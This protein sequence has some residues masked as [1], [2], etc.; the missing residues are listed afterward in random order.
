[1]S[2]SIFQNSLMARVLI[3][4]KVN[5][6]AVSTNMHLSVLNIASAYMPK[7]VNNRLQQFERLAALPGYC[8][9]Q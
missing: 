9:E 8:V 6:Q 2:L 4:A 3:F 7:W 1:M 5:L